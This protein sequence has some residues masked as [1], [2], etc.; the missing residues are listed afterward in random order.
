MSATIDKLGGPDLPVDEELAGPAPAPTPVATRVR[1]RISAI[2][3]LRGFALLGI[4]V[5][6]INAFSGPETVH[7]FPLLSAF[8]GPHARLNLAILFIKWTF[9]EAKMRGIFSMLFGA[10][11]ILMTQRAARR[12][13]DKDIADIYLRRNMLLVLIGFLHGFLLWDGDILFDYGLVALLVLYPCR[14]LKPRTLLLLG[15]FLSLVVATSGGFLFLN[16]FGDFSLSRRAAAVV[17]REQAGEPITDADRQTE[18]AWQARV[19]SQR[20]TPSDAQD[21]IN[22]A[23]RGYWAGVA[24]RWQG[25][26][27]GAGFTRIHVDLFFDNAS[28]MLIGMGLM[29]I[30]FLTGELASATYLWTALIGFAIS[31][32]IYLVGLTKAYHSGFYFLTLETWIWP[33]YYLTREAGMLAIASV[34]LLVIKQGWLRTPQRLLAAVGRT[35][36]SNYLLTTIL[37]QFLFVWGPWQLYGTLAYYQTCYVVFAVWAVNLIVSPLW[38]RVFEFGPVEWAWRS[39]T[40]GKLQPMRSGARL[41][42]V[43]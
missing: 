43:P 9:F 35:A 12:G 11:V 4:L 27:Q 6:N 5:L 1:E 24:E 28:A 25:L 36:L 26:Y 33:E 42:R 41:P 15:T 34:I 23:H 40:Y 10:G 30:G 29:Q 19:A 16:A 38:L 20:V 2:D 18:K 39:L 13:A 22:D 37:C 3:V 32:P 21:E 31:V 17:A 8:A 14:R 7:D